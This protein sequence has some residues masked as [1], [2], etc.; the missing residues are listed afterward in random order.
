MGDTAFEKKKKIKTIILTDLALQVHARE[1]FLLGQAQALSLWP[2]CLSS[3]YLF[4]LFISLLNF[5]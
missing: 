5:D 3:F 1:T 2:R 4:I